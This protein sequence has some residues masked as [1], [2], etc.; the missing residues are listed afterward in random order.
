MCIELFGN[1]LN[2]IV[3]SRRCFVKSKS[4]TFVI[5]RKFDRLII[6]EGA[7]LDNLARER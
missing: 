7:S 4:N 2:D 1:Q 3:Y 5:R 6:I